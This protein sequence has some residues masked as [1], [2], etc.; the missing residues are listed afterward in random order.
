MNV[1]RHWIM[2]AATAVI[3]AGPAQASAAPSCQ[4]I[5]LDTSG[6]RPTVMMAMNGRAPIKAIF[7]TGNMS[8][9]VDLNHAA[10][11]G[12]VKTGPLTLFNQP[13]ATGYQTLLKQVTVGDLVIGNL[14]A[15]AL[16]AMMPGMAAVIGPSAFGNRYVTLDFAASRLRICPK[17][18]ANR[19]PGPGESYTP[20]PVVLPAVRIVAGNL[21]LAGHIDT[22]SP[23]GLSFPLRFSK[24][25]ALAAPLKKIGVARSHFG[26]Q[27]IYKAQIAGPVQ[28]GPLMLDSP[29]A[30]FSDVVPG[31]N[32]GGELLRRMTITIDPVA[33]RAWTT[34]LP[35]TPP[36]PKS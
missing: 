4:S 9:T 34:V 29:Q 20:P 12:L 15:A 36:A 33:K 21:H 26:E 32:V 35:A 28:V 17:I 22:G 13:G 16:P 11:F 14:S 19:P 3:A 30:Y 2:V 8:T 7:D 31:P 1:K 10:E 24:V 6:P 18:A 25:F 5:P 23:F 27:P